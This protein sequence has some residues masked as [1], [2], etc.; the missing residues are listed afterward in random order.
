MKRS[1]FLLCLT[2]VVPVILSLLQPVSR[3]YTL[4]KTTVTWSAAQNYCRET[5]DDLA[6][7]ESD[8]DWFKLKKTLS[9]EPLTDVAWVGL[10]NDIDSWKWSFFDVPLKNT[11][12]QW[13]SG[14]PDNSNGKATCCLTSPRVQLYNNPCTSVYSFICFN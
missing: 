9:N 13:Y 5:Y 12:I 3:K 10:Y 7:I 4:I 11:F 6:T 14:Y 1:L 2:G 8:N